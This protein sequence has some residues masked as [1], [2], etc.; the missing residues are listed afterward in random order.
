M[1]R[2]NFEGWKGHPIVKYMDT[3]R[4][5]L[6]KWLKR[7]ICLLGLGL[8]WAQGTMYLMESRHP[9]RKGQI[10]GKEVPIVSIGT[11]CRELCKNGWTDR[12]A[13]WFVD[14]GGPKKAQ[15]QSY[16]LGGANVLTCE[17][18]LAPPGEYDWTVR[19]RRRCGLM[20]N[21]FDHLLKVII[22]TLQK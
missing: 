15:V 7:S 9:H 3:L 2:G 12:F 8:V 6:H 14:L 11:V 19:L 10:W 4:S 17:G 13:V 22:P 18:T 5:S 21:Y 16:S 1:G 20:S